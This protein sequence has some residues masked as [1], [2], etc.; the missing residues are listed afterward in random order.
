MKD[1]I[2]YVFKEKYVLYDNIYCFLDYQYDYQVQGNVPTYDTPQNTYQ[3]HEP[4]DVQDLPPS[5]VYVPSQ[6]SNPVYT[7]VA[8][9]QNNNVQYSA[10]SYTNVNCFVV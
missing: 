7:T 8:S 2:T 6:H 9:S 3:A 5:P 10:S 1:N 4:Q